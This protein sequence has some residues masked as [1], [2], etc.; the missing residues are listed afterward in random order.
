ML[1]VKTKNKL[2]KCNGKIMENPKNQR[3]TL[4]VDTN[5]MLISRAFVVRDKIH[6]DQNIE[7]KLSGINEMFSMIL[8]QVSGFVEKNYPLINEIALVC[9]QGS[10]RKKLAIPKSL[11]QQ[12][13]T[14]KGH[15]TKVHK[16]SGFEPDWEL[17]W[18]EYKKF[19][20]TLKN[21]FKLCV[22]SQWD[23]EGDDWARYLV[24]FTENCN[25]KNYNNQEN[26]S[27]TTNNI[28]L[29]TTDCDWKQL[30]RFSLYG[31]KV[32]WYNGKMIS[33][34][35]EVEYTENIPTTGNNIPNLPNF[36][37]G[38]QLSIFDSYKPYNTTNFNTNPTNPYGTA[39]GGSIK[40]LE[41]FI[42]N[43]RLNGAYEEIEPE[44][45]I[46][47]KILLGDSS[48]NIYPIWNEIN[49]STGKKVNLTQKMLWD[50]G[51][52]NLDF[53]YDVVDYENSKNQLTMDF[54][55]CSGDPI[56]HKL[57]PKFVHPKSPIYTKFKK[58]INLGLLT[59]DSLRERYEYNRTLVFLDKSVMGV[60]L[61]KS[62]HEYAKN[63]LNTNGGSLSSDY[64]NKFYPAVL[65]YTGRL[66]K[67]I[68]NPEDEYHLPF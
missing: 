8:T 55:T 36:G 32:V 30:L 5:Y 10:W 47:E 16:A 6:K 17:V 60:P 68:K 62:M 59:E 11:E 26:G 39:N 66:R 4:V 50:A 61:R 23:I 15:R 1:T 52:S 13:I 35:K 54:G 64:K 58:S 34:N 28:I 48:D 46:T 7:T 3:T 56:K 14:Y 63:I 2:K 29:W 49:G 51:I 67:G 20:D 19:I 41:Q 43:F 33:V 53:V 21:E 40:T 44:D 65:E 22:F 18:A 12:N 25:K 9:D 38:T 24:E 57:F 27:F 45:I 31:T 37:G 42:N